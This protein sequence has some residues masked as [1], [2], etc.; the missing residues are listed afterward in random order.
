[1]HDAG[2][3]IGL[4]LAAQHPDLVRGIV[5]MESLVTPVMRWSMLPELVRPLFR[6]LRSEQGW[7]LVRD[8]NVF[9]EQILKHGLA[10]S[11]GESALAA[12]RAPFHEPES[13]RAMWRFPNQLPIDGEPSAVSDAIRQNV[14]F[15]RASATPKLMLRASPGALIPPSVGEWLARNCQN[16]TDVHLGAGGHYLPEA[17]P[18]G[19]AAALG[20]WYERNLS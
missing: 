6:A 17:H 2:G 14:A 7:S 16:M 18:R 13:R 3:F 1:M 9:I 19:I 20:E 15:L 12:Y 11:D 8:Q 10:G 5:F 4:R